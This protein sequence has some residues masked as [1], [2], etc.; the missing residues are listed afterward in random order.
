MMPAARVSDCYWPLPFAWRRWLIDAP[1]AVLSQAD[2]H[3]ADLCTEISR[4]LDKSLW[5]SEAHLIDK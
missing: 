1:V 2:K 4:E 5:F 3:S